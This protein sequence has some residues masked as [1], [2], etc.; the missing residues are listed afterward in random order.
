VNAVRA[1]TLVLEP[2][3][4]AHAAEMFAVLSDPALYEF[5]NAPPESQAFLERRFSLL[6]SRVSPSG[7]EHWLNW[8]IRTAVRAMLAEL[9][10]RYGVRTVSAVVKVRNYR[11]LAFL[12]SLGFAADPPRGQ[13]AVR[14][15]PDE[16]VMYKSLGTANN[17]QPT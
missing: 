2:Q 11:S 7:A 17:A 9:A 12:H 14:H 3:V 16:V 1:G 4:G 10:A 13:P 15:E 8:V 6:E 5:E